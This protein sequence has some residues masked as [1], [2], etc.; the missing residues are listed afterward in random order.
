MYNEW[1]YGG[2]CDVRLSHIR[3]ISPTGNERVVWY[4]AT[5]ERSTSGEDM[6]VR[7]QPR[8]K[9]AYALLTDCIHFSTVESGNGRGGTPCV[10]QLTIEQ[11]ELIDM[12]SKLPRTCIDYIF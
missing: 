8:G 9:E 2:G 1:W 3:I 7:Q 6:I 12:M 11:M 5:C 4:D 10:I